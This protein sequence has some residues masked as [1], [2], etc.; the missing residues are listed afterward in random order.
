[1]RKANITI[2]LEHLTEAATR[3]ISYT[4]GMDREVF[5]TENKTRE[6]V[7]MNLVIIGETAA[8]IIHKYPDFVASN[9]EIPWTNIR[10]MR[11]QIAHG[12]FDI[13]F[14]VVWETVRISLPN[15]IQDIAN[16]KP[17]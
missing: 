9:P 6:A 7:A 12:Y 14:G 2:Y 3:A 13:D 5:L 4:E 17:D 1:M 16:I 11:N 8:K 15:L 10:G